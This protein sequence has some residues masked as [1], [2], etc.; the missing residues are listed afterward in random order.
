MKFLLVMLA[1]VILMVCTNP[2]K[3]D[4][5]DY[6]SNYLIKQYQGKEDLEFENTILDDIA[7]F[8]ISR[9]AVRTDYILFSIYE[10]QIK[11][12]HLKALG[13]FRNFI[14]LEGKQNFLKKL[15]NDSN[16]VLDPFLGKRRK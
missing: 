10:F 11:Q 13:I 8:A 9:R 6:V 5:G 2:S 7:A 1:L 3:S 12:N 16:A 14:P 15:V 4:L